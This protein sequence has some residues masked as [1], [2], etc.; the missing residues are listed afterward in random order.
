VKWAKWYEFSSDLAINAI[1]MSNNIIV[2]VTNE[3]PLYI[4][5]INASDGSATAILIVG[6]NMGSS[7]LTNNVINGGLAIG[8]LNGVNTL[9]IS[10]TTAVP[11]W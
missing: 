10:H 5:V 11:Q 2:A 1:T 8:T 6:T 4:L 3:V 7:Y 9:F